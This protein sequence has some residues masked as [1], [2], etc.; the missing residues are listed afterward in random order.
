MGT[1]V[2][3]ETLDGLVRYI[4]ARSEANSNKLSTLTLKHYW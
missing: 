2:Y 1:S 3:D 4:N